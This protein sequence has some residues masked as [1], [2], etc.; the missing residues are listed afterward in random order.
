MISRCPLATFFWKEPRNQTG[1]HPRPSFGPCPFFGVAEKP[2]KSCFNSVTLKPTHQANHKL[3]FPFQVGFCDPSTKKPGMEWGSLETR[4][5][6]QRKRRITRITDSCFMSLMSSRGVGRGFSVRV[7]GFY[8]S[9]ALW[10]SLNEL[11]TCRKAR[12]CKGVM[13]FLDVFG[14]CK[15][16]SIHF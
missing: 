9:Y 1:F 7:W 2:R 5:G 4:L 15:P 6:R 13:M 14:D 10:F 12:I 16:K 8:D 11:E 3:S